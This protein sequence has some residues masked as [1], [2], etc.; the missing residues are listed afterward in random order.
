LNRYENFPG[1]ATAA[2]A[3]LF[4]AS[5]PDAL[6]P[7]GYALRRLQYRFRSASAVFLL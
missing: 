1:Q 7:R 5:C 3:L 6:P 4:A 2:P